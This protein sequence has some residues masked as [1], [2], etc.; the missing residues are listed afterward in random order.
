MVPVRPLCKRLGLAWPPQ[1][2]RIRRD[3][4]PA[5]AA[6][7]VTVTVTDGSRRPVVCLPA[8]ML[9]GWLFGVST[10]RVK[11]ENREALNTYRRECFA[12]LWRAFQ[13][14]ELGAPPP[15]APAGDA[16]STL[17][18]VRATALAV[19]ALAEQQMGQEARITTTEERL[20]RAA[21]VVGALAR[22]VTAIETG[23]TPAMITEAQAAEVSLAVRALAHLMG[24][25][26]PDARNPD[27]AVFSEIYRQFGVSSYKHLPAAR[28]DD[29]L[30]FL[31]DWRKSLTGEP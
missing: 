5:E 31:D 4:V 9:H 11:P 16:P 7:T 27:G 26:H 18:Q 22:R 20:D 15:P 2:A 19:A 24:K 14:G 17:V 6:A 25:P 10:G 1:Y 21:V 30:A 13:G 28:F 29:V 12:V 8:D 3:P 23:T